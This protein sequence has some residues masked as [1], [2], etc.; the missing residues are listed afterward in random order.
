M[1]S[2]ISE[3]SIDKGYVNTDSLEERKRHLPVIMVV[4]L[5]DLTRD[6]P[7]ALSSR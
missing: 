3:K 4:P 6:V 5:A 1:D 2:R 7:T